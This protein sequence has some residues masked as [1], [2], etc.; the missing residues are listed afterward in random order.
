MVTERATRQRPARPQIIAREQ[1]QRR[2]PKPTQRIKIKHISLFSLLKV[3]FFF[4]LGLVIVGS[5]ATLVI[6]SVMASGGYIIKLN[7]LVDQLFG[8]TNYSVSLSQVM[9]IQLS[10]GEVWVLISTVVTF[11]G[12]VLYNLSSEI[13]NGRGI[14]IMDDSK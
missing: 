11:V 6:W 10:F 13:V 7:H 1:K 9:V 3:S 4:Y 2:Q 12:G 14:S 8:T 5:L